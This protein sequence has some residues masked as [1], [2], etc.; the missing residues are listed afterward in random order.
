MSRTNK[1]WTVP[2][3][4]GAR[5]REPGG[6][7]SAVDESSA[8]HRDLR[9]VQPGRREPGPERRRADG[10]LARTVQ[11]GL[12]AHRG[13]GARDQQRGRRF[14]SGRL[15]RSRA[16]S[17]YSTR[18]GGTIGPAGAPTP[19]TSDAGRRQRASPWTP[20][21]R[22]AGPIPTP[23]VD[24]AV[25]PCARRQHVRCGR[26]RRGRST[27]SRGSASRSGRFATQSDLQSAR[28]TSG[29]GSSCRLERYD[30][31]P[32][33]EGE[34]LIAASAHARLAALLRRRPHSSGWAADGFQL[35]PLPLLS[36][37]A[38]A[39]RLLR[40]AG[41]KR[42]LVLALQLRL[43]RL[44]E[45]AL[46]VPAARLDAAR[47]HRG[48]AHRAIRRRARREANTSSIR[49]AAFPARQDHALAISVIANLSSSGSSSTSTSVSRTTT[50]WCSGSGSRS[51]SSTSRCASRSRSASA[52][53]RSSR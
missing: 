16:K 14:L 47:L 12:L 24:L 1:R 53:I 5:V 52:S 27:P 31:H 26:R 22:D 8:L 21:S 28:R 30:A 3:Q 49:Q 20:G 42:N 17:T 39:R 50:R 35:V 6:L 48:A 10:G 7:P 37:P 19:G 9:T 18:P 43:L 11:R 4:P 2:H 46:P 34:R 44:G 41:A 29:R 23:R 25:S 40:G 13:V 38:R 15:D 36:V 45:S 32:E 33:L 51:C